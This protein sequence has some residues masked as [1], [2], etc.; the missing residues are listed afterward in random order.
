MVA[1]RAMQLADL[2]QLIRWQTS[3]AAARWFP[4][5]SLEEAHR[6]FGPR[7]RGVIPVR[8]LVVEIEGRDAG[9]AQLYR[10][11]DVGDTVPAPPG[12]V[13]MDFCIGE[14]DLLGQGYGTALLRELVSMARWV[15]PQAQGVLACP[16][17][18]NA[19]SIRA[20]RSAGFVEGLW[21]DSPESAGSRT[22]L[23]AYLRHFA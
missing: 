10:I 3:P 18:R 15:W 9:Y 17:H 8:M 16:D 2:P 1:F 22:T 21:F 14:P 19:A 20:L 12:Y 13:A 11:E 4:A 5:L 23:V 6:R 7:I